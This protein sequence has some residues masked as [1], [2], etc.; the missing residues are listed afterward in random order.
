MP[1]ARRGDRV[2]DA[3]REGG[4]GDARNEGP[5]SAIPYGVYDI[6]ADTG[7]VSVGTDHDTAAFAVDTL[8]TWWHGQGKAARPNAAM[9]TVTADSGGSDGNRLRAWKTGLAA[10]AAETGLAITVPHLPPGTGPGTSKWSRIEHRLFSAITMNW[11]GTPL[12]SHESI[13]SLIGATTA[14]TGLKVDAVLD[15]GG[16]PIGIKISDKVMHSL[17]LTRHETQGSGTT[18]S[19]PLDHVTPRTQ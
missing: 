4:R 3:D 13:V 12:T 17:P 19:P 1:V 8:R 15:T 5:Q 10:L 11:R 16:Y 18:R 2:G 14:D 7:R 6:G 9:L